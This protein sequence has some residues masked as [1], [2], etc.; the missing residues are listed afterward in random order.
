MIKRKGLYLM[1]ISIHGLIRGQNLELGRDADTG[2]QTTYVVELLK[3]LSQNPRVERVDLLTRQVMDS[4]V[5]ASYAVEEE[6]VA[7]GA[8]IIRIPFGPRRYLRKESL[9]PYLDNF[10]D[11]S[12]RHLRQ[13]KR[14]PDW[15]HSHYADAGYAGAQLA[16][17]LGVPLVHT[18]HSL[19]RVKKQRL[20]AKGMSKERI[21]SRYNI[22]QRIEA[23]E[24]TLDTAS[25]V[26]T[27]TRQEV[28]EQYELYD[29]YQPHR[30]VV[31]PPGTDLNRFKPP[32]DDDPEPTIKATLAPFLKNP[33]KPMILALSRADERKNIGGLV[34]AYAGHPK[35]KGLANLVIVAGNRD[36]ILG[37]DKGAQRV[38]TSLLLQVDRHDLYGCVAYPK[39][40]Q[41]EEVPEFYRLAAKS[42]GIFVNPAITEPFG[43][44]I[45]EAAASGLPVVATENGGPVEIFKN[46]QNGLLVDPLDSKAMGEALYSAISDK[47]RWQQW[48]ERGFQ[49]AHKHYTWS[50]H[51]EKYLDAA[52]TILE[53]QVFSRHSKGIRSQLPTLD[54]LL[55]TDIDN[56]LVGDEEG[57]EVLMDMLAQASPSIGIGMGVATGRHLESTLEVL[58]K[59][60]VPIPDILI[61]SVGSEIYYG[62]N[63]AMDHSW[64][65]HID[66]RWQPEELRTFMQEI[67]G[68]RPQPPEEQ[69]DFK[70]SYYVDAG[71]FSGLR[72]LKRRMRKMNLHAKLIYSHHSLLDLLP[73]RASKGQAVRFI[74]LK[75]GIPV[76]RILTAGD[77]GN[78]KEM[79]EGGT[80]GV[81]VGNHSSELSAL[82]GRPRVYFARD[83]HALGIK[84][85]IEHY[86]FLGSIRIPE[87]EKDE[88]IGN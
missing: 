8:Y 85:G 81:V 39:H 73:I 12:L 21:E 23:E 54:R 36:D 29:N 22:S 86:N 13:I 5:D 25:L 4:R 82:K 20:K 28:E 64:Q 9:W 40:H 37:L 44:T 6:E 60:K 3:A 61:T 31:L 59:S 1:L 41:V 83:G 17:L 50:G 24:L 62:R 46:C 2:G 42:G 79:I 67:S 63:L 78:D 38:L 52:T 16:N 56:T 74:S 75:W 71:K 33:D 68:V 14:L 76:R 51:V 84:E 19:G 27:S 26:V 35:L 87:D 43:L 32:Q 58:G 65:R 70:L 11:M 88:V 45:I 30:M 66:F 47:K 80:L 48:S 10:A 7:P 49:G 55:I 15:I 77:S 34:D 72:D 69:R 53:E 18:G 57:L